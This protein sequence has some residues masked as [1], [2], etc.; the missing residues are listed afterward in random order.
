MKT[1]RQLITPFFLA[2]VL[3]TAFDSDLR[4]T[5]KFKKETGKKCTF[6][7][8]GIP[9]QGDEDVQLN[10]EGLEFKRNGYQ[11]TS[12]QKEIPSLSESHRSMP[13]GQEEGI[14][15]LQT[16]KPVRSH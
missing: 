1:A 8:S 3:L 14:T 16:L 13:T 10:K 7:H 4:G 11:L 15:R 2:F 12:R 9:E 5:L 6:C